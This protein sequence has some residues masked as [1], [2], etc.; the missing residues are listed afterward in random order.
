MKPEAV[1]SVIIPAYNAE[2]FLAE[3]IDS[4]LAQAWAPLEVIVVDDGSTDGTGEVCRRYGDRIRYV[5]QENS[6]NCSSPRNHGLRVSSGSLV[7]FFDADDVMSPDRI[8][9]QVDFL[10][11]HPEAVAVLSDYRNFTVADGP[12]GNSHFETCPILRRSCGFDT[13]GQE[14]ALDGATFRWILPQENFSSACA[15]MYRREV[16]LQA[17]G[18]DESLRASE[19]FDLNYRIA[20]HGVW[21]ILNRVG[22]MRRLHDMNMSW[23]SPRIV[24]YKIRSRRKLLEMESAPRQR[25]V[26]RRAL[27][28]LHRAAAFFRARSGLGSWSGELAASMWLQRIPTPGWLADVLRCVRYSWLRRGSTAP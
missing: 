12:A 21:G 25:A 10:K 23:D 7:A 9:S 22:F 18:Y 24:E 3:C 2:K 5:R 11:R 16:L 8:T 26:L 19:D 13:G 17:G 15:P 20:L 14:I 28:E 4:V 27:S 1:V 6:G